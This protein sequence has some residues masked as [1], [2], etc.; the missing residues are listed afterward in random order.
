MHG[1]A[2]DIAGQGVANPIGAIGSA[3]LMLDHLGL[4]D[5]AARLD[6]AIEAATAA[7]VLTPDPV[8]GAGT[9]EATAAVIDH[10]A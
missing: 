3:A 9:A 6:K 7:G 10:L 2:P 5:E 8:G 4:P 1:S